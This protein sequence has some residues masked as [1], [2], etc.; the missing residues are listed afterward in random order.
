MKKG[1]LVSDSQLSTGWALVQEL[2]KDQRTGKAPDALGNVY[3]IQPLP[4]GAA[5][6]GTGHP[7]GGRPRHWGVWSSLPGPAH[8]MPRAPPP[9]CDSHRC[10][11]TLLSF[12]PWGR[13]SPTD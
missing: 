4:F 7:L 13:N 3:P 12:I 5:D 2:I 1:G 9:Q 10:P 6:T 11:Q 8:W